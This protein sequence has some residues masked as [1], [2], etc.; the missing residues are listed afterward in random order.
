MNSTGR[1]KELFLFDFFITCNFM[2]FHFLLL[3]S[4]YKNKARSKGFATLR[5]VSKLQFLDKIGQ[6][7]SVVF[8]FIRLFDEVRAELVR[9]ISRSLRF[10]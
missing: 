10:L 5:N 1:E 9:D 2:Q 4:L 8:G 7:K 6:T 3:S